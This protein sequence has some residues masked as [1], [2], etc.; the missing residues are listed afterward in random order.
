MTKIDKAAPRKPASSPKSQ[1]PVAAAK[2]DPKE[3]LM[4]E[5]GRRPTSSGVRQTFGKDEMSAGMGRALRERSMKSLGGPGPLP[6]SV[7]KEDDEA[8]TGASTT[9]KVTP[10]SVAATTGV[11]GDGWSVSFGTSVSSTSDVQNKNGVTT[12][13]QDGSVAVTIGG[14]VKGEVV[15]FG[16]EGTT[17]VKTHYQVSLPTSAYKP[18][19][20]LDPFDPDSLPVGASV[21]MTSTDFKGTAFEASYKEISASVKSQDEKGVSTC[22]EK[23]GANTVRVTVG[24]TT[25][26]QENFEL[27]VSLGPLSVHVGNERKDTSFTMKTAEFDLS[28]KEGRAAYDAFLVTGKMPTDN[29]KGI[30][31]VATI[32][33]NTEDASVSVGGA[34]GPLSG[35]TTISSESYSS[36]VTTYPD[37]SKDRVIDAQTVSGSPLHATVHY[38]RDGTIDESKTTFSF[39]FKGAGGDVE[40]EFASAYGFD[41]KD[42]KGSKDIELSF[43]AAQSA[44]FIADAKAY[45]A[46][47][48]KQNGKTDPAFLPASDYVLYQVSM[49]TT[50]EEV[51]RA[52]ADAPPGVVGEVMILLTTRGLT[53]DGTISVRDR[54]A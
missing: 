35:S 28:T 34:L 6:H 51:A 14:K 4:R 46:A 16:A 22:I 19:V 42:V 33:K 17:G 7:K 49:A 36:V 2:A 48:V 47:L 40:G 5:A 31:G 10:T 44:D 11:K 25:L 30:S 43:T 53:P 32:E 12:I 29:S 37:G 39:F 38:N 52:L 23:T 24:P 41:K 20:K 27:G 8:E 1:K 50:P 54:N 9:V 15:G 18:G 21:L 26:M 3:T 13:T 45:Y